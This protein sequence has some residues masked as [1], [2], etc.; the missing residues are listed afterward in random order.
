MRAPGCGPVSSQVT[1]VTRG[2]AQ[3]NARKDA[4]RTTE[5]RARDRRG[6]KE[7][8]GERG[9]RETGAAKGKRGRGAR[10]FV[11]PLG[12]GGARRFVVP[13]RFMVRKNHVR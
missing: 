5:K 4:G 11:V 10:R 3:R 6:D 12:V 13:S 8:R 9:D 7:A 1:A 2:G